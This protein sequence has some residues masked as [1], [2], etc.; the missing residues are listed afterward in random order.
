MRRLR[1]LVAAA[2]PH[3]AGRRSGVF[4]IESHPDDDGVIGRQ[5]YIALWRG[6]ADTSTVVDSLPPA[7]ILP[8]FYFADALPYTWS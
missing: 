2:K 3:N 1:P 6:T 7:N 4:A 8:P 5:T